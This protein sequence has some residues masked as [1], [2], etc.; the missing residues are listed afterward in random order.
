MTMKPVVTTGRSSEGLSSRRGIIQA[1]RT[2]MMDATLLSLMHAAS[3]FH[4]FLQL[5]QCVVPLLCN[6]LER[7]SRFFDLRR[8]EFPQPFAAH[9]DVAHQPRVCEHLQMLGHGLTRDLRAG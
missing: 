5:R 6:S 3:T 4:E 8:F 9:L 1:Q 2:R 7:A